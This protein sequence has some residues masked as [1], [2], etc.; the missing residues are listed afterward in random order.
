M[1]STLCCS[2]SVLTAV[3]RKWVQKYPLVDFDFWVKY[4]SWFTPGMGRKKAAKTEPGSE[5]RLERLAN[6]RLVRVSLSAAYAC[7]HVTR[8]IQRGN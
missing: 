7:W 5:L 4:G 3:Q 2:G 8:C 6:Q 1:Y